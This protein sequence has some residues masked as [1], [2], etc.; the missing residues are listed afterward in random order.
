[1]NSYIANSPTD[2]GNNVYWIISILIFGAVLIFVVK[3]V[4]NFI[5]AYK[6]GTAEFKDTTKNILEEYPIKGSIKQ[7]KSNKN[8]KICVYCGK[9][10][11]LDSKFCNNCGKRMP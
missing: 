2:V 3:L 7:T 6:A 9:N 8:E 4:Y 1:M 5:Q 11:S 10:N